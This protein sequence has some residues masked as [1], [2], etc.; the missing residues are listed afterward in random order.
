MKLETFF[1]EHYVPKRLLNCSRNTIR[2]Y[3]TTFRKL[4][5]YLGRQATL[6]DLNDDLICRYLQ[7]LLENKDYSK[8]SAKKERC[9][10]LAIWN[11]AAKKKFVAEFPQVP[12]I[13]APEPIPTAWTLDEMQAIAK[14]CKMESRKYDGVNGGDWWFALLSIIYETGERIGAVRS[15]R[16]ENIRGPWITFTAETRKGGIKNNITQVSSSTVQALDAIR[17]PARFEVFPWPYS[18]TYI[19]RVYRD[20]LTKAGLDVGRR[21]MFHKIRRTT[22]THYSAAGHDATKL[23]GHSSRRITQAYLDKT[24]DRSVNACDVLPRLDA[25]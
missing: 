5:Q 6:D 25:G 15:L 9:N 16:W 7:K 12:V 17:A 24:I 14:A 18:E 8:H 3:R 19:Y 20:I 21:S 22:A 2:L 11:Y 1:F 4:N 13:K 10:L 23:L